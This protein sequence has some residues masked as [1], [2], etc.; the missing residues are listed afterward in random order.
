MTA[1]CA[2]K[3]TRNLVTVLAS[4]LIPSLS[5]F[6]DSQP[7]ALAF[8]KPEDRSVNHLLFVFNN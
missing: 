1:W 3:S 5:F 7:Y 4:F 2:Q 8:C 6:T